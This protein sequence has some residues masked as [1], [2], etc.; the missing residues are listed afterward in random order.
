MSGGTTETGG[1]DP[2]AVHKDASLGGLPIEKPKGLFQVAKS[3][4]ARLVQPA[5]PALT[6]Q[7]Q[8]EEELTTEL[9]R[10]A[11]IKYKPEE[12]AAQAR[13]DAKATKDAKILADFLNT[14]PL[15]K[16]LDQINKA[17]EERE[18]KQDERLKKLFAEQDKKAELEEQARLART[19]TRIDQLKAENDAAEGKIN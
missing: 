11:D 4:F 15:S 1:S 16:T 8:A 10:K 9:F 19:R 7:Q 14:E 3:A 12:E 18:A 2:S 6:P 13:K 5:K 17:R